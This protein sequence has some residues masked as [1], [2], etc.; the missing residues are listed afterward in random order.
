MEQ[1]WSVL[2]IGIRAQ[3]GPASRQR[4]IVCN[5]QTE[6]NRLNIPVRYNALVQNCCRDQL[7]SVQWVSMILPLSN[8]P[9][10]RIDSPIEPSMSTKGIKFIRQMTNISQHSTADSSSRSNC[11]IGQRAVEGA[12]SQPGLGR[13]LQCTAEKVPDDIGVTYNNFELVLRI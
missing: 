9:T 10:S 11:K 8:C 5:F 2:V 3:I 6:R 13:K 4:T 12:K 7:L 1:C